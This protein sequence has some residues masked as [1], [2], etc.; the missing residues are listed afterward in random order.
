ML[1]TTV[2]FFMFFS[3]HLAWNTKCVCIFIPAHIRGR[4]LSLPIPALISEGEKGIFS[5]WN[6]FSG[7]Q[8]DTRIEALLL[9]F[10]GIVI[11]LVKN[12]SQSPILPCPSF[13]CTRWELVLEAEGLIEL[14]QDSR[15]N[16]VVFSELWLRPW[17]LKSVIHTVKEQQFLF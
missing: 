6:V 13:S 5:K 1:F 15:H 11:F 3:K 17:R 14:G 16:S 9:R 8:C 4:L 12:I 2:K 10:Y 7:W